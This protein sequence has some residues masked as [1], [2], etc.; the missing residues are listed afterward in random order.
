M[1][2][3]LD[4]PCFKADWNLIST[5]KHVALHAVQLLVTGY[6][7][8]PFFEV[9]FELFCNLGTLSI[10]RQQKDW[11]GGSRK[12]PVLL[13]FNTEFM[14]IRW[15]GGVQKDQNNADVIWGWSLWKFCNY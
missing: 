10:L 15:V 7:A 12:W 4:T 8:K 2:V 14:L 3:F 6:G 11:V 9:A 5:T 1:T 13:T